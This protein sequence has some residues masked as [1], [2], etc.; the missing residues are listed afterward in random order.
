M[1]NKRCGFTLIELV[2]VMVIIGILTASAMPRWLG[3]GG[4]EIRTT[5]DAMISRLRLVQLIN[6]N[7]PLLATEKHCTWL[8]V[9]AAGLTQ[10]SEIHKN[11]VLQETKK[12]NWSQSAK[13]SL[14]SSSVFRLRF[15]KKTG[16]AGIGSG[17]TVTPANKRLTLWV[18]QSGV[19]LP[20][21]IEA[22][23]FIHAP[24]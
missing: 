6:M 24:S 18:E 12:W 13:L 14:D 15:D 2:M 22:E 10:S 8:S 11:G 21:Y 1:K 3:K 23:G 5:R 17:C 9:G 4:A 19:K 20:I 7:E 16:R